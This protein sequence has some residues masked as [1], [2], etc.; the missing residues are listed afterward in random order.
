LST[1][2]AR[3]A[4]RTRTKGHDQQNRPQPRL[5]F[6]HGAF[7]DTISKISKE[8]TVELQHF[9][10]RPPK[11]RPALTDLRAI[12][13]TELRAIRAS[14]DQAIDDPARLLVVAEDQGRVVGMMQANPDGQYRRTATGDTSRRAIVRV[15]VT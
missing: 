9:H 5:H 8:L 11:F 12:A 2:G 3:S 10:A 15:E 13:L 7:H 4:G 6:R 14:F 1:T